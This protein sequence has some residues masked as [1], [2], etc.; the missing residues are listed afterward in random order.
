MTMMHYY[1][2]TLR[3]QNDVGVLARITVLLRKF[4]VNIRSLHIEPI[5]SEEN[6]SEIK[7]EMESKKSEMETVIKKV[8][9][10]IP[11]ISID[12]EKK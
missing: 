6:F 4:Q 5:D 1:K 11:V 8:G 7:M 2:V 9:R 12:Y 3:V 10:L